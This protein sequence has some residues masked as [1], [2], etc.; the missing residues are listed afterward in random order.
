[1]VPLQRFWILDRSQEMKHVG[2]ASWSGQAADMVDDTEMIVS[3]VATT[4]V[5]VVK[6]IAE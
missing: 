3:A 5:V 6:V 4:V 2:S 1:M